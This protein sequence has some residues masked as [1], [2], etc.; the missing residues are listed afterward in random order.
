[1]P[2]QDTPAKVDVHRTIA[3]ETTSGAF[4]KM[5]YGEDVRV[6]Y[7]WPVHGPGG[8]EM[9]RGFPMEK[10]RPNES[11]DHPHHTSLWFA[12][13]SVNGHDFWHSKGRY[14]RVVVVAAPKVEK[15]DGGTTI[16]ETTSEWRATAEAIP[17][18][19]LRR[20]TF[21]E[22]DGVRTIDFDLRLVA[23]TDVR[24]GDTK[25]GTLAMRLRPEL[26]LK[27]PVAQGSARDADGRKDGELWGKRTAWLTYY[28]PVGERTVG[29]AVFDHPENLRHPTWWHARDYGLV[30]ANPFGI[31]DF[32]RKP[33]G[34]G[35]LELKQGKELRLRYRVTLFE[36]TPKLEDLDAAWRK[37]SKPPEG[38]KKD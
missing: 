31:H 14:P 29:V 36:G 10:G 5:H 30:A 24:F 34:T 4:T 33:A 8:V 32:E 23:L 25:E 1:M 11:T 12:H 26:R 9:T 19:E 16:V 15:K 27:G 7:L 38:A 3:I 35:D 22:S 17:L 13:G 18:R 21:A 2:L 28:G 37:W 6:P 20:T